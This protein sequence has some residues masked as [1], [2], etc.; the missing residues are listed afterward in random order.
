M[1]IP[2]RFSLYGNMTA[3]TDYEQIESKVRSDKTHNQQIQ[4]WYDKHGGRER[5]YKEYIL[6]VRNEPIESTVQQTK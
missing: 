6:E 3:M 5:V 4:D 2:Q 1:M